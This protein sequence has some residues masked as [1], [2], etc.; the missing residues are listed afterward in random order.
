MRTLPALLLLVALAPAPVLAQDRLPRADFSGT[1]GWFSS[2]HSELES[3]NQWANES[4]I[5]EIG[6]G[7]YWTPHWKTEALA[8]AS[9]ETDHYGS[10][11]V[12]INGQPFFSPAHFTFSTRRVSITQQYQ[13]GNNQWFHPYLGVGVDGVWERRAR[14]DEPIYTYDQVTRRSV[15]VKPEREYPADTNLRALPAAAAGFKS[16]ITA[17]GFFRA[18]LRVTFS[19][20]PDE[21]VLRFGFGVDF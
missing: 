18:D 12:V 3:Y 6:A 2:H 19:G 13:F 20:G 15:L 4:L 9:T 5:G 7:F 16:Y 11:S 14:R 10:T 1:L 17:R 21:A 8:G